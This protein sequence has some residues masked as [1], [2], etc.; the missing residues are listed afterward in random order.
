MAAQ[1]AYESMKQEGDSTMI[2]NPFFPEIHGNFGFGLIKRLIALFLAS[3]FLMGASFCR[4]EEKTPAHALVVFFSRAGENYNVGVIEEGNTAKLAKIIAVQ[5]G[6]DLFEIV[7]EIAYPE[8]YDTML[9]IATRERN[10][11]ERPAYLGRVE[12]WEQYDTVFIGYPI[13]WGGT[14]MILY[15]FM[16]DYDWTGKIVIPFNTHEG[17]GQGNTVSQ[18]ESLCPGAT[19]MKGLA[20]RGGKAQN[21]AEGTAQD[22]ASWLN[23]LNWTK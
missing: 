17:S 21:D 6:A 16:E 13:W 11:D 2:R 10:H 15:S 9:D 20:V 7:P 4:A 14:P 23:G 1:T 3:F 22:V 18:I 19:M 8:D 12:N 5:T